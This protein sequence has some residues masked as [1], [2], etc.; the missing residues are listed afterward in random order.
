MRGSEAGRKCRG[1]PTPAEV[2]LN[3]P[4]NLAKIAENLGVVT[5]LITRKLTPKDKKNRGVIQVLRK[6][7]RGSVLILLR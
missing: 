4:F 6:V 3:Q 7:R 1:Y 2:I 5:G